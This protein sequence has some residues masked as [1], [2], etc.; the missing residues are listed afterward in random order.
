MRPYNRYTSVASSGLH[1][2][3]RSTTDAVTF[4]TTDALRLDTFVRPY[5]R[6]TSVASSGLHVRAR[7]TTDAVTFDTTDAQI[8]RPYKGLHDC[9]SF[10]P[11]LREGQ[12]LDQAG[13][14][15]PL[16]DHKEDV[17]DIYRD[18]AL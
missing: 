15:S 8:V 1:V 6:Y 12:L 16:V 7:S 18:R 10:R 2:R 4:D 17:A 3:A 11:R 14:L 9:A 5:S 13:A